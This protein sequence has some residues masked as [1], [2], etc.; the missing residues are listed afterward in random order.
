[1]PP[2]IIAMI[3]DGLPATRLPNALS[4]P[5]TVRVAVGASDDDEL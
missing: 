2:D 3:A 5:P 1:M 4:L